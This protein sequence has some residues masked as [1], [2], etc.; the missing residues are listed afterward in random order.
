MYTFRIGA[1]L[2]YD[3]EYF[4]QCLPEVFDPPPKVADREVFKAH[5]EVQLRI[6]EV[7]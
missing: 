6:W 1:W 3:A 2:F 7:E 4:L 5:K